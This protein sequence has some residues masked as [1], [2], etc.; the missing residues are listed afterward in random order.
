MN[1]DA[2]SYLSQNNVHD[3]ENSNVSGRLYFLI[4][5]VR[6]KLRAA[7][8]QHLPLAFWFVALCSVGTFFEYLRGWWEKDWDGVSFIRDEGAG[9]VQEA[10]GRKNI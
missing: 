6:A 7:N 2:R 5:S 4:T 10:Q 9:G 8:I 3:W 1:H